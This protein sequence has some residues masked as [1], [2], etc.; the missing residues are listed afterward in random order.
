MREGETFPIY[1]ARRARDKVLS[2]SN[3]MRRTREADRDRGID[4]VSRPPSI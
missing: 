2:V 1:L 4:P 3:A